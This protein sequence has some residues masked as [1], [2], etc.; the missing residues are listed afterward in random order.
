MREMSKNQAIYPLLMLILLIG[1]AGCQPFVPG[2][3]DLSYTPATVNSATFTA[4]P[5]STP[6]LTATFFPT[7]VPTQT[8]EVL[9]NGNYQWRLSSV[10]LTFSSPPGILRARY[11]YELG[12]RQQEVSL[13]LNIRNALF[14]VVAVPCDDYS[15]ETIARSTNPNQ[16]CGLL[17]TFPR[18]APVQMDEFRIDGD[19]ALRVVVN[20]TDLRVGLVFLRHGDFVIQASA[21]G[22]EMI[23]DTL[24]SPSERNQILTWFNEIVATFK[25]SG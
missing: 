25:F 12:I 6:A 8:A 7:H 5:T 15:L 16:V 19:P 3:G 23:G 17:G 13:Y 18:R 11:P 4:S 21:W 10:G 22:G 20:D 9:A 14:S 1:I 2:R 24:Y